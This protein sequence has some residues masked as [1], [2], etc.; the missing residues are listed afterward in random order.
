MADDPILDRVLLI[1]EPDFRVVRIDLAD[2]NN[3]YLLETRDGL[4]GMGVE[5]WRKFELGSST[6]LRNLFKYLVRIVEKM[7]AKAE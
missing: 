1:G 6:T 5:R 7:N 3:E 4:D 2:G